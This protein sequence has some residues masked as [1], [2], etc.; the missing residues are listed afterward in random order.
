MNVEF[1][2]IERDVFLGTNHLPQLVEISRQVVALLSYGLSHL[3]IAQHRHTHLQ[4]LYR[5]F[6]LM[7]HRVYKVTPHLI[8]FLLD[9]HHLDEIGEAE[10]QENGNQDAAD[11]LPKQALQERLDGDLQPH[12]HRLVLDG[13]ERH[14]HQ[15]LMMKERGRLHHLR[16]PKPLGRSLYP[17]IQEFLFQF[18][19]HKPTEMARI[20]TSHLKG[21]VGIGAIIGVGGIRLPQVKGVPAL[22][23]VTKGGFYHDH[24][25]HDGICTLGRANGGDRLGIIAKIYRNH[26]TDMGSV[27]YGIA[28]LVQVVPHGPLHLPHVILLHLSHRVR[29]AVVEPI[30][31]EDYQQ[32]GG[33][34]GEH[35]Y[36]FDS[37]VHFLPFLLFYHSPLQRYDVFPIYE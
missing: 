26:I 17:G 21:D 1:R 16:L 28:Q 22:H 31:L 9:E 6:Q 29:D 25:V 7:N 2:D 20:E 18:A 13:I 37:L 30:A 5:P 12:L 35:P 4:G 36:V 23:H 19:F 8:D 3:V 33:E 10:E 11:D 14:L 27:P 24:T 15:H 32:E 34:D